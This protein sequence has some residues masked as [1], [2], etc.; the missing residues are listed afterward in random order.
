MRS[1]EPRTSK[2][3]SNTRDFHNKN[4]K[5]FN[6]QSK[7]LTL[8]ISHKI[9]DYLNLS[10][11]CLIS[12]YSFI[13]FN[14]QREWTELY[15]SIMEMRLINNDLNGYISKTEEY[16]LNEVDMKDQFKKAT[17]KDLIYLKK[18]P[19][20]FNRKFLFSDLLDGLQDGKYQRGY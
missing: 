15:S 6:I 14:S 10:L 7:L 2:T 9:L 18:P 3:I 17:S 19:E 4:F 1:F 5:R 16:F 13:A 12:I 11:F 20:K 8:N